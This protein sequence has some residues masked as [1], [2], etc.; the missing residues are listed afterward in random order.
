MWFVDF[1]KVFDVINRNTLFHK[2]IHGGWH[3]KVIDT[4][5]SLYNKIYFRLKYDEYI[6]SPT[7]DTSGVN[8]GGNASGLL[9][10]RYLADL[11]E[12][13]NTAFGI[14]C[15]NKVICHLLGWWFDSYIGFSH[16]PK[17]ATTPPLKISVQNSQ[18]GQHDESRHNFNVMYIHQLGHYASLLSV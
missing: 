16:R 7:L 10:R 1:S 11:L 8:Q 6:S 3:G 2:I 9:F 18:A 15:E 17:K 12:Y 5:R 14:C 13:L 4:L